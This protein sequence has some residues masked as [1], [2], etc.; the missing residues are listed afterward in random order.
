MCEQ[1]RVGVELFEAV[2]FHPWEQGPLPATPGLRHAVYRLDDAI[3][4]LGGRNT[5]ASRRGRVSRRRSTVYD[6]TLFQLPLEVGG[7]KVPASHVELMRGG[8]GGKN[9]Q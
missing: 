2:A 1:A 4:E 3:D 5:T 9:T 6:F 7:D 8:D